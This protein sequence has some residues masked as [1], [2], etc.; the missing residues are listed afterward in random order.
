[1]GNPTVKEEVREFKSGWDD[2]DNRNDYYFGIRCD[3][4]GFMQL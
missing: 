2:Y 3:M 1:M 4:G